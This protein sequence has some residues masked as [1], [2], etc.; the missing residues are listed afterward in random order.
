M[1]QHSKE[2]AM[3]VLLAIDGSQHSHAALEDVA[4]R[5]WPADTEIEVL[6]AVHS[7]WPLLPDPAFTMV[8]AHYEAVQDQQHQA[9]ALLNAAA[10]RVR[11]RAPLR[12]VTTKVIEGV[13]HEVIVREAAEWGADLI[14]LGSHGYG[15]VRQAL[16][17]SVATAVAAE[18]P[19]AVEIIRAGRPPVTTR[20][21]QT[22]SASAT[23][24]RTS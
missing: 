1:Q 13:P 16:L 24:W 17:G 15:P 14:V 10:A 4:A 20:S 19:C 12:S 23:E 6:T 2:R 11:E 18:A 5:E 9:P 8:A 21:P 3:K 22:S 7:R